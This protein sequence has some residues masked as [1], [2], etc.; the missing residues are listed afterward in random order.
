MPN[1]GIFM[2]HFEFQGL[3]QDRWGQAWVAA[4]VIT[5]WA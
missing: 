1:I 3:L 5:V 4:L 2:A